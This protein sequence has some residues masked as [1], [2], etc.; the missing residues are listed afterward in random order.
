MVGQS[1]SLYASWLHSMKPSLA[2]NP[3][4]CPELAIQY[5]DFAVWQRTRLQGARLEKHLAYWQAQLD[6]APPLLQ[7]PTDRPRHL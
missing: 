1:A 3:L 2:A 5:P 4:P 6:G 7:L